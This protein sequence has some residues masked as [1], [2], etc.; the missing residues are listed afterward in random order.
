MKES[1]SG[2]GSGDVDTEQTLASIVAHL[3]RQK[4]QK[5]QLYHHEC[6]VC[7]NNEG[8]DDNAAT[9]TPCLSR[10]TEVYLSLDIFDIGEKDLQSLEEPLQLI[11]TQFWQCLSERCLPNLE[12]LRLYSSR[13]NDDKGMWA[14]A[15]ADDAV[16]QHNVLAH[17]L[18]HSPPKW[19]TLIVTRCLSLRP[20]FIATLSTALMHHP[21]LQQ[22][23]L[24][25][26]AVSPSPDNN[27]TGAAPAVT[28]TINAPT[29]NAIHTIPLLDPLL[30]ALSTI[31]TLESVD[32]T[33]FHENN[34]NTTTTT[35]TH[36]VSNQRRLL[37]TSHRHRPTMNTT[38]TAAPETRPF[39]PTSSFHR[40]QSGQSP[41][42]LMSPRALHDLLTQCRQLEDVSLWDCGLRNAHLDALGR[43]LLSARCAA[44][45]FLS[46]RRHPHITAAAWERFYTTIVPD[47]YSLQALYHDCVDDLSM[48]LWCTTAAATNT[49]AKQISPPTTTAAATTTA[50]AVALAKPPQIDT[51]TSSSAA[52]AAALYL[53]LNRL[54]RGALLRTHGDNQADWC[55]LLATVSYTP[56]AIFALLSHRPL[57]L[58]EAAAAA[59]AE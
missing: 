47:N 29:N 56:S 7:V 6:G 19:H 39:V 5:Q 16:A 41:C 51:N 40:S 25:D 23:K 30:T 15:A 20:T 59:N 50:V 52:A 37:S 3:T 12:T 31:A 13:H 18:Q 11:W 27:S 10:V 48:A 35:T 54:G 44:V 1:K 53:C 49:T 17:F 36:N 8:A 9:N 58:V 22:V 46:L 55:D 43:A 26:V 33:L 24:L 38:A 32:L 28:I 4:Q 2:S 57:L 21:T 45:R 34:Q 14:D 42:D